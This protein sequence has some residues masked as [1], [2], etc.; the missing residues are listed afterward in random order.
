MEIDQDNL[1]MKFS[2]FSEI[3]AVQVPT[4]QIQGGRR[5]QATKTATP[6]KTGYFTAIISCSVKTVADKYIHVA[7][8]NKH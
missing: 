8:H 4:P 5:R 3:L 7:Y 2:A 1:H 6:L